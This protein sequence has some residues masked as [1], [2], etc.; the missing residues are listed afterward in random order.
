VD[1]AEEKKLSKLKDKV[2][3]PIQNET[4]RQKRMENISELWV[5]TKQPNTCI[6]RVLKEGK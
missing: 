3:K 2:I 5:N 4:H 6:I 1:T